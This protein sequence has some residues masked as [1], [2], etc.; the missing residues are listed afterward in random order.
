MDLGRAAEL[1]YGALLELERNQKA[2]E[3]FNQHKGVRLLSEEVTEDDIAEIVSKWTGIPVSK[4]ME[5][6][7]QKL[8]RLEEHLHKRVI[9]QDEAIEVV[10]NA[11]RRARAGV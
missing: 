10:S 11:V 4:L 1:K 9:G 3:E 6:E 5:G 7:V 2:E 8:L